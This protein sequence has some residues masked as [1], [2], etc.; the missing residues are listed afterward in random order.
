V[1]IIK[2][3]KGNYNPRYWINK[4]IDIKKVSKKSISNYLIPC[5]G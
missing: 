4:L 5:V 2:K 3:I 1:G